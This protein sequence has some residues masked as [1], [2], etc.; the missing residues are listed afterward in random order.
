MTIAD[1]LDRDFSR[2]IAEMV[3]VNNH[4]PDTVLVELTEYIATDRIKAEFESLF[5]AMAAAPKSPKESTG[6]WVSGRLG[7]GKSSFAKNLGYVLANPGIHGTP[8]S[9]LFLKQLQSP[10]AAECVE[11]LNRSVPYE[12]VM[13]NVQVGLSAQTDAEQI[14][15]AM[16]R[17]LRRVLDYAEDDDVSELEM[18]LEKEGKLLAFQELCRSEYNQEW[19][20]VRKSNQKL[21]RSSALL[22]RL[23]ARTYTTADAW[24][25]KVK[26]QPSGR[27]SI[28]DLVEKSFDLCEIRRPGKA[29]AFIVD[30]AG[31]QLEQGGGRL[32]NLRAVVQQFGNQSLERVKAGR[33][34]G[35]AWIVVTAH[36]TLGEIGNYPGASSVNLPQFRNLFQHQVELGPDDIREFA[37]RRVLRKKASQEPILRKMFREYGGS[38]IQNV[39]LER[40]SRRTEFDEDQFVQFYPYLPH[41]VDV[42]IDIMAGIRVQPNVLKR[43]GSNR[44][45]IKQSFEMLVSERTR[46]ADLPLGALVSI[47]KIYELVEANIPPEKQKDI[48]DIRQRFDDDE[49]Y[50]GM[51]ARVAKAICL[52]EFVPADL[53]RTSKN[54]AALLIQRVTEAAP[55]RAVEAILYRLKEAQ[56]VLDT[57]KGWKLYDFDELRGAT[58]TLAGLRRAVG[59]VNPRPSGWQ[60]DLI[61]LGKKL[62]ARSLEWQTRPL[63]EFNAAV[64]RS[65]EEVVYALDH[66][67]T[68]MAAVDQLSTNKVVLDRLSMDVTALEGRMAQ[69]EMSS[70]ALWEGI[71]AQ[72][73]L[74]NQ[75]VRTL[76]STGHG[77]HLEQRSGEHP[78]VFV[79]MRRE[80]DRTAYLIGLFGTGR[81]YINELMLANIGERAKYFR[82][83]IGLHPGPTPMI[84]S[85]HATIRH[86]SRGQ[87][88][89]EV[90][91]SILKAVRS[92][93]AD[94]IF[95]YRHPLDSLLTNWIWWRTYI[96]ENRAISGISQAY[97]TADDL[98]AEVDQHF[99]EF[100]AF[101]DGDP[102][103]FAGMP[104]PRFLSFPEFVEETELHVQSATL[105]LGLENFIIDP[106]KEFSK[107]IEVMSVDLDL[108]RVNVTPPKTKPYRYLEVQERVPRFRK[109]ID[110]LDAET[111]RRIEKIGYHLRG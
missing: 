6:V 17:V 14:A 103:F 50:P 1:L 36:E 37:S 12:V 40:C 16:Y 8:A 111:R 44:T 84:Y 91:R 32:E 42:S 51:A 109:L 21:L 49:D 18:K 39:K 20:E 19:R 13:L 85:G 74:L 29:V 55:T 86:I 62:L 99:F 83:T 22:N 100:Q 23:D 78:R 9:S 97:L 5:L 57:E 71:Q 69:W 38:L 96:R 87:A 56:F 26:T 67:A 58:A 77:A 60:N 25:N 76:A 35:P 88:S 15:D 59:V 47:D 61:Q 92:G 45:I 43:E 4:D 107:I 98:C 94:L 27:L 41:L 82:D 30:E 63:G 33:I 46:L 81:R 95:V 68:N 65:L 106:S 75:E 7:A 108:S 70:I 28:E 105:T 3:N 90:M 52:L 53:P 89:P 72:L 73:E 101:A 104:G 80:H 48:S 31:Q 93:F 64:S 54:I 24:I 2:P 66:L 110:G 34:P 10:R 102:D 79:N 11:F